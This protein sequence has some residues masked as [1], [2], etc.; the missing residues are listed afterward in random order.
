MKTRTE[1]T[2]DTFECMVCE[3][4]TLHIQREKIEERYDGEIP[5]EETVYWEEE[6]TVCSFKRWQYENCPIESDID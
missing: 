2:E 4:D 1:I 6:C 3:D 5:Y